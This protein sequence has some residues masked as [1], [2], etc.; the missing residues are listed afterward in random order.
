MPVDLPTMDVC[1]S[2]LCLVSAD[3]GGSRK[4]RRGV[5]KKRKQNSRG[6]R[7]HSPP[8]AEGYFQFNTTFV[9]GFCMVLPGFSLWKER[10]DG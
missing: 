4:I 7:G 1:F 6:S 3:S 10:S 2:S 8:D 9:P 5:L